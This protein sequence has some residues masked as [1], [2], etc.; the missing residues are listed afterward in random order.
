MICGSGLYLLALLYELGT[1]GELVL[2]LAIAGKQHD[3][4]YQQHQR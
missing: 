4:G 1:R 2:R 3:I